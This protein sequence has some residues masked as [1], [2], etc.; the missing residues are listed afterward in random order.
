MALGGGTWTTQNKVLP[1]AY[2]NFAS[3]A[4]A[5]A[6]LSERGI[7][8]MPL[9][10][11]WGKSGE[12]FLVT[13][14]DFQ[15]NSQKIF[16]YDY[17]APE[18]LP[19]REL[20]RFAKKLYAYRLAS[21]AAKAGC[22]FATAKYSGTRGN[23]IKIVVASSV[24]NEGKYVVSTLLGTQCVD[25][26]LV[27]TAEGLVSN[28]YVDFIPSATLAETAGTALTGGTNGAATDGAGYQA[29]LDKIES[30]SFHVL[31]CP[32]E[33]STIVD[34]F[35]AFT[36]RMRDEIGAKFQLVAWH[37]G[38]ADTEGVI[39]VENSVADMGG[40]GEHALVYWTCGAAAGCAVNKSNT[41][42]KYDGELTVNV[43][44]TQSE[45]EAAIRAGKFIFHN[46]GGEVRVLEDINTLVTLSDDKGEVFQSN[47]TVRVC[48]QIANDIA[49]VFNTR[50]L[51]AVPNDSSGRISFWSDVCKI[52][53]ELEKL[54]AIENFDTKTVEVEQ[55]DTKKSVICKVSGLNIM[56]AMAQLYMSVVVW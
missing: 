32:T 41:N 39:S 47:Q 29:F 21:G 30:Y 50:Y 11:D 52:H 45:L 12:V 4:K 6:S 25:V 33:S 43:D 53:Q 31:G 34:L 24:D 9:V 27:A 10:L 37:A 28:D 55:G 56:N 13:D 51:G 23:A 2:I 49:V 1:G 36:K 7:V 17:G 8:A 16:G 38:G 54:R 22:V 15:K 5:S 26:Q 3:A 44:F 42:R 19:L 20:F 46:A 48:D 40:L 18:M 35:A 14:S